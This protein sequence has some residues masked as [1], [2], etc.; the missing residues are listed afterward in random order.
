MDYLL[1]AF[2]QMVAPTTRRHSFLLDG[3]PL[4]RD[5]KFLQRQMVPSSTTI[6]Y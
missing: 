4:P 3:I 2:Y 1:S 6:N 5:G